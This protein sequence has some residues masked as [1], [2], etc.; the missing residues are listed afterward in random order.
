MSG[1]TQSLWL[2]WASVLIV[3]SCLERMLGLRASACVNML[4][5]LSGV[6]ILPLL[7]DPLNE[8]A[9][10]HNDEFECFLA[11]TTERKLWQSKQGTDDTFWLLHAPPVPA[12][13]CGWPWWLASWRCTCGA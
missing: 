13:T 9:S 12:A 10:C 4:P 8:Q 3:V 11:T 5:S 1:W 6:R 2:F 7:P